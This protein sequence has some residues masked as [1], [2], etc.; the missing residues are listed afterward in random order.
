MFFCCVVRR[1]NGR[2]FCF[3]FLLL[4]PAACRTP[5]AGA[6]PRIA[7]TGILRVG[8]DP[9]YP[10]FATADDGELRGLD[11]DLARALAADLDLQAEF[12]YFGYDGLY[13]ALATHQVDV[14]ISALVVQI[15][16]T[17]DFA[18]SDSYF[19][20]GEV[21]ITRR[22]VEG[23]N[24]MADMNDRTLAVELGALGHVEAIQWGRRLPNLHILPYNT[25][26]DALA[27]ASQGEVDAVLIDSVSARL[28]LL[29]QP[30]LHIVDAT[31]TLE[32]YALVLRK[33][34]DVLLQKLNESLARLKADGRLEQIIHPWLGSGLNQG[35]T[36]N[37]QR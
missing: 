22:D 29:H 25:P 37:V 26:D 17:R 4:L 13:D 10:P 19:N 32:P 3:F 14:L 31:V 11:V 20:A 35:S 5:E 7:Q 36:L 33:E 21:L 23:I 9:T 1:V 15:E 2:F 8:L 27:A 18:Y 28:Y 24:G 12:V 30:N 6:W 16:R 34:D